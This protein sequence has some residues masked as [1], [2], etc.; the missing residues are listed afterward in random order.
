LIYNLTG[1]FDT[2]PA[3]GAGVR[4]PEILAGPLNHRICY[5]NCQPIF[6][7]PKLI[8]NFNLGE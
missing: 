7:S 8:V 6:P 3:V 4:P 5:G 1:G 2:V